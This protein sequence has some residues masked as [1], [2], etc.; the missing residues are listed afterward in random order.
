MDQ[1]EAKELI[2]AYKPDSFMLNVREYKG[3]Y[4]FQTCPSNAI[5]MPFSPVIGGYFSVNKDTGKIEEFNPKAEPEFFEAEET[6]FS[7]IKKLEQFILNYK[8]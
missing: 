6:D 8:E 7:G 1:K 5:I 4:I 2:E 3:H